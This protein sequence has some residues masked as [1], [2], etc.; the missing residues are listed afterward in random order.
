MHVSNRFAFI[1][2]VRWNWRRTMSLRRSYDYSLFD[3]YVCVC[4]L[5]G[6]DVKL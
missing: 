2:E 3:C 5:G 4:D 6:I 1:A